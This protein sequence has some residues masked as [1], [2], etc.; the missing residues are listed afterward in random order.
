MQTT[1]DQILKRK[2]PQPPSTSGQFLSPTLNTL[3]RLSFRPPPPPA[4]GRRATTPHQPPPTTPPLTTICSAAGTQGRR[5]RAALNCCCSSPNPTAAT[6]PQEQKDLK[7]SFLTPV[8]GLLLHSCSSRMLLPCSRRSA[9]SRQGD[10]YCFSRL[11][12]SP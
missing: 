5:G 1:T 3:L 10:I 7:P 12:F 4:S 6:I 8:A 11:Q 2:E 9:T